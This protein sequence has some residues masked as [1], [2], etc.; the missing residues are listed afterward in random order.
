MKEPTIVMCGKVRNHFWTFFR[1]AA[2]DGLWRDGLSMTINRMLAR[3]IRWRHAGGSAED[4]VRA[5]QLE[6]L[7]H[8]VDEIG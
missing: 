4:P 8:P 5:L 2:H 7:D 6:V 1:R 3:I